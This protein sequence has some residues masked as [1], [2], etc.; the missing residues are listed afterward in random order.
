MDLA[1]AMDLVD[2]GFF[3]LDRDWHVRFVNAAAARM[4]G[5]EVEDL[6]GK[7]IWAEFPTAVGT[8]FDVRYREAFETQQVDEFEEYFDLLGLWFSIRVHPSAN[9][10]S[11]VFRDITHLRTMTARHQGLLVRQSIEHRRG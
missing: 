7:S 10:I 5:R 4:L 9:G 3:D 11:L 6:V 8:A 1:T 2:D